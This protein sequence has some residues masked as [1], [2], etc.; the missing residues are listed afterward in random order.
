MITKSKI[1]LFNINHHDNSY[2]DNK[3]Y[4]WGSLK[5]SIVKNSYNPKKYGYM[6]LTKDNFILDGH[7]RKDVLQN[8]YGENY[9]IYVRKWFFT[10]RQ[11]ELFFNIFLLPFFLI[12]ILFTKTT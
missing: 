7:H 3:N 1:K 6:Y 12:K 4:K 5:K 11:M 10:Y 2:L 9:E 8:L